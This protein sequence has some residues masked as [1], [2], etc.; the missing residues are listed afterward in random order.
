[1]IEGKCYAYLG[2]ASFCRKFAN[3]HLSLCF[4]IIS[5]KKSTVRFL[6]SASAI[7]HP[8]IIFFI[9][10]NGMSLALFKISSICFCTTQT[11]RFY[12]FCFGNFYLTILSFS[13]FLKVLT[14]CWLAI[15]YAGG[16]RADHML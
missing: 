12:L 1:M 2:F 8:L 16:K 5:Q 13:L 10:G 11:V 4:W 7:K 15:M 9:N 6:V 14:T 3:G